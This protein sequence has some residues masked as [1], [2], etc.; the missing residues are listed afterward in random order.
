MK[1]ICLLT[2][3]LVFAANAALSPANYTFE[4]GGPQSDGLASLIVK[5]KRHVVHVARDRRTEPFELPVV[6]LLRYV[7]EEIVVTRLQ[8]FV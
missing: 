2:F 4:E 5:P 3:A 7:G 1:T 6:I 8:R